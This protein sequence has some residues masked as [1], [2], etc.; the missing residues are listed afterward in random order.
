MIDLDKNDQN[1]LLGSLRAGQGLSS[2]CDGLNWD[3][4]E[5]SE[6][7]R[8]MPSFLRECKDKA[9]SGYLLIMKEANNHI[10]KN[11]FGRF[12]QAITSNRDTNY[13]S[14]INLWESVCKK[15]EITSAIFQ[16]TLF[17]TKSL[18][19]V[20]T[21]VGYS[22]EEFLEQYIFSNDDRQEYLYQEGYL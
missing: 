1:K 13:I 4:K 14:Q 8:Q 19:E 5:I 12:K 18:R 6:Y 10:N 15:E 11:S 22:Y 21:C 7:L 16:A 17:R 20:A 9:S 3:I 2:A